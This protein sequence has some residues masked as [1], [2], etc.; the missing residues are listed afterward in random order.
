M[1]PISYERY[2]SEDFKNVCHNGVGCL[3]HSS[4][5]LKVLSADDHEIDDFGSGTTTIETWSSMGGGFMCHTLYL[6]SAVSAENQLT[7]AKLGVFHISYM[8]PKSN[9]NT[10]SKN[11]YDNF[12]SKSADSAVHLK[13]IRQNL[14]YFR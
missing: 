4:V 14:K 9:H 10:G 5:K 11:D 7:L 6:K 2:G 13:L 12:R 1:K 8:A 3:G